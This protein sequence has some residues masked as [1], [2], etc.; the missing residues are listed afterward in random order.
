MLL[1]GAGA[2]VAEQGGPPPAGGEMGGGEMAGPRAFAGHGPGRA[3]GSMGMLGM[4]PGRWWNDP[5]VAQ[6]LTLTDDQR[7]KMDD[8]FNTHRI[9]LIDTVATVEKAEAMLE[10]LVAADP[11]NEG[12]ILAQIGKVAEARAEL[13]KAHARMLLALRAQLTHDQWI[14]LQA[15]RG[16]GMHDEGG[17]RMG[18]GPG[19]SGPGGDSGRDGPR[20]QGMAH[21]PSAPPAPPAP[22][23]DEMDAR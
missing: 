18:G 21:P 8:I 11:P 23:S 1:A 16:R 6:Q 5:H 7:K 20:P 3:G 14:K 22:A 17:R 13:E 19:G 15:E 10:P 12:A 9:E 4:R 2:A